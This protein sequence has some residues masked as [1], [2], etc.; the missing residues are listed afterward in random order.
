VGKTRL[1]KRLAGQLHLPFLYKDGVKELLFDRL[2]WGSLQWSKLLSLASYDLLFNFLESLLE[3]GLSSVVEANFKP[4]EATPKFLELKAKYPFNPFQIQC[5]AEGQ[6]L[7]ERFR[8]RAQSSERHPGHMDA[9]NEGTLRA[10]LLKGRHEPLSIGGSVFEVDMTDLAAID[11][12]GLLKAL[13]KETGL[14]PR[15]N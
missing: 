13:K 10:L 7:L 5:Y 3:A 9:Q 6:V 14:S 4:D 11:Y 12:A 8:S 1:G 2:G 15:P